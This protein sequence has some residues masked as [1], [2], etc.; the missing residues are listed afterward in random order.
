MKTRCLFFF[1]EMDAGNLVSGSSAFSET[2]L[3]IR[4][5]MVQVVV[6]LFKTALINELGNANVY[7]VVSI[8]MT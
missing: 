8:K 6:T 4:K 1:S 5:F 3:N 7:Q 2:S